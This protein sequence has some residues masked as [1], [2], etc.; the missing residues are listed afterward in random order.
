MA[1]AGGAT[2]FTKAGV[3]VHP[4][5]GQAVFFSYI[6]ENGI[7]DTELTEH[8]GCPVLDGEKRVVT[9]WLRRGVGNEEPWSKFDAVGWRQ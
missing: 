4:K 2:S 8:S 1:D 9:Q 7:M 6:G 5:R 3:H